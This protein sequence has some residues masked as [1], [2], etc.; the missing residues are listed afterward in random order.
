MTD[1]TIS[2]Q[3]YLMALGLYTVA[4]ARARD[5]DTFRDELETLLGMAAGGYISDAVYGEIT[6]DEALERE[7]IEV[8]PARD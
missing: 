4:R 3:T 7:G 2:R 1:K 8:E 6:L 5:V